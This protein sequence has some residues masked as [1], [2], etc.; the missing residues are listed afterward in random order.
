MK[1]GTNQEKTM[2]NKDLKEKALVKYEE[3]KGIVINSDQELN[4]AGEAVKVVKEM[5][6]NVKDFFEPIKSKAYA[7]WKQVGDQMKIYLKPLEDAERLIKQKMGSYYQ[8]QEKQ[9]KAE[10]A[11]LQEEARKKAEEEQLKLAEETGDDS[12]LDQPVIA[13]QVHIEKPAKQEGISYMDLWQFTIKDPKLIPNE[14]MIPNEKL[15]GQIVRANK[16]NTNI[17]GV[18]VFCKKVPKVGK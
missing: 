17:P 7:T 14:Y 12:I 2:E 9:R 11:R 3:A 13:P 15:I 16:G 4:A 10:E 5:Q 18:E 8:E 1:P 6:K